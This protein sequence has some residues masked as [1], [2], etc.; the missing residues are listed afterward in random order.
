MGGLP[1]SDIILACLLPLSLF[2]FSL[3]WL[4]RPNVSLQGILDIIKGRTRLS[5]NYGY[6]SLERAAASYALYYDMASTELTAM[7]DSYARL[8]RSHK[9]LGY[10]LGYPSKLNKLQETIDANDRVARA[11]TGC[12]RDAF[13]SLRHN[14]LVNGGDLARVRETLKH[15]IRDWST[16]GAGER[17]TIFRPILDVLG[18]VE[19]HKRAEMKVLVPGA[20]LCRLAWEISECGFNTTAVELSYFMTLAFRL[21]CSP[22]YTSK[23][24]QHTLH[25]YSYWFSH[26]RDNDTVFRGISFPDTIPNLDS[27]MRLVEGDFLDHRPSGN[28]Y[29][30]IVTLFF[31][32]TS[33]NII[34]TLEHIYSLLRPGGCWINLGPLLWASGGQARME[35][36]LD[37]V[38]KLA[39]MTGFRI[40]DLGRRTVPCEYTADKY[41]MMKWVY[42]AEFWVATKP[43]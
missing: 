30:Y 22:T 10:E 24:G 3:A 8:G 39:T 4:G 29:D 19:T 42:Q 38:I 32:D 12:A 26:Q 15:F 11:I 21:L 7:R 33:M 2:T 18:Q 6:F 1:S 37:E 35:L 27:K 43:V 28:K 23:T 13:P 14:H 9:R 20:G 5:S 41:A 25:P 36:S 16:E 34:S 17:E 40:E 31:I